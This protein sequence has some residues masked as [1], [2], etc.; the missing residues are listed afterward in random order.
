MQVSHR[1]SL[2]SLPLSSVILSVPMVSIF[3][4]M[5]VIPRSVSPSRSSF[6]SPRSHLQLYTEHFHAADHHTP[7]RYKLLSQNRGIA[8]VLCRGQGEVGAHNDLKP[9]ASYPLDFTSLSLLLQ[10]FS[11]RHHQV[12]SCSSLPSPLPSHRPLSTPHHFHP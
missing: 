11:L 2:L 7:A 3:T 1:L 4:V 12:S 8:S 6:W 5:Q 9:Q 10:N